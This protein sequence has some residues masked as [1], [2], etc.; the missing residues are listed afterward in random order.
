M[1]CH[2]VIA[3]GLLG[4]LAGAAHATEPTLVADGNPNP[5]RDE[6][7]PIQEQV[8]WDEIQRNVVMLRSQ[9]LLAQPDAT[10]SVTY[11]F[12]LRLAPGLPDY[13]G[14]R[15]S[16][17]VDHNPAAGVL[18]YNGGNRTYDGHRGTDI[19]LWPFSWNKVDSGDMQVI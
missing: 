10:Q 16:A 5:P 15:I 19:A 13:A 3:L 7:S 4:I 2:C 9:A 14:F 17:F 11:D 8:L 1:Y 6:L 18:D 12:P